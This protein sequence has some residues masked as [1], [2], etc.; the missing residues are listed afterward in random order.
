[1]AEVYLKGLDLQPTPMTTIKQY[2]YL[3]VLKSFFY[4]FGARIVPS[5]E[6]NDTLNLSILLP[7][8]PITEQKVVC[9]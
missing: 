6:N 7:V 1:M 9:K 3:F 8:R 4:L 5:L 2:E